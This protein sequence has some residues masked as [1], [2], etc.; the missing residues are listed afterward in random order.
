MRPLPA[1]SEIATGHT[2][3]LEDLYADAAAW[4]ADAARLRELLG[5]ADGHRGALGLSAAHLLS[6]LRL[7]DDIGVLI[8]RLGNYAFRKHDE[9][10]ADATAQ[11]MMA[12]A[13]SLSADTGAATAWVAPELLA[14]PDGTVEAFLGALPDLTRYAHHL[15]EILR[16]KPHV[17]DAA[18]ERMLAL[19]T[20][21]L[22][23][24]ERIFGMFND[25]DIRFGSINDEGGQ[26]VEVTKGRYLRM[27]ESPD[28]GVRESAYRALYGSYAAWRNTL[29]EMLASQV[30][31]DLFLSRARGYADT[32]EAA[33]F[34]DDIPVAVYD[35]VVDAVNRNL[36][37]MH[38]AMALRR[39]VLGVDAVR[40]WD[41]AVPLAGG[42]PPCITYEEAVGLVRAGLAPLGEEYRAA[43][44]EAVTGRWI[45]VCESRGKT[46]GAYSAWTYGAHPFILLNYNETLKDVF[47]LAHELGHALHSQCTW[48]TQ[49]PVYGGYTI[50]CAEVASTCNEVLLAHHLLDA[51]AD[52]DLRLQ[53]LFH[54]IDTIRG[55]VYNQALF[56]EF[57]QRLHATAAEGGPLTADAL[58]AMMEDL[59][60]RY[61]GP[62][63]AM[64]G[65]F[66]LNW[67]RIPHFYR[68]FYVFQYATGFAAATDIATRI[69]RGE[70]G[71]RDRYLD[72]LRAGS[73]A[74]SIDLLRRAGVDMTGPAPI[75][76][77]ARLLD[78]LLD[79]VEH[80][81][82]V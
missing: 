20:E 21:A 73:S 26:E 74:S 34:A 25:A 67:S 39:R 81:L 2:W 33:L 12:R 35:H 37:P 36:A 64:D 18:G 77:V 78:A 71:A 46:S 6:W 48:R 28:R 13:V 54:H 70:D 76:A 82:A 17:L 7:A 16:M 40:P 42:A 61:Y 15:D 53:V 32:R 49:P 3:R 30:R 8:G 65:L 72:F 63:F 56:A 24:P 5:R 75:E 60:V 19:A 44:E 22:S 43:L 14:L 23:A 57:E 59:Y 10:T 29:A 79:E 50:F 51:R 11:A 1:R 38:R 4:E 9:D 62:D 31:A 68:N 58:T 52:R 27:Q 69:L 45:D 55:T 80:T 66:A 41:L 47:T